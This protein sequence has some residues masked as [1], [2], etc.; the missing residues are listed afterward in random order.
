M[1]ED[2]AL[3]VKEGRTDSGTLLVVDPKGLMIDG[4][5]DIGAGWRLHYIHTLKEWRP[6]M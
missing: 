6:L 4:V 5:Q 2:R 1:T 3:L